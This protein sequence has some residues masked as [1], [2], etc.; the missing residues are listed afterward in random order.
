MWSVWS[1]T[2]DVYL[3]QGVAMLKAGAQETIVWRGPATLP[4]E[5]VLARL[6]D[7]AAASQVI[8]KKGSRL[9][10]SLSGAWCPATAVTIPE[11]VTR[12]EEVRQI[13][14]ASAAKDMGSDPEQVACE[15]DAMAWGVSAAVSL[16]MLHELECWATQ[17][18]CK[19]VSV[20]P[21][22]AIATQS[23]LSRRRSTKSLLV[24]EPDAAT[25]VS[26]NGKGGFRAVTWPG[27]MDGSALQAH[28]R[29]WL[30]GQGQDGSGLLSLGFGV[31]VHPRMA[32]GPVRWS[33]HWYGE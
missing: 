7:S 8:L 2:V 4:L 11:S 9:R 33:G 28:S 29:Q 19:L 26:C 6:A 1:E 16:A 18:R 3:G 10:I 23:S 15:M 17:M 31:D 14:R 13:A 25:L 32:A 24:K 20:S 5:R 30:L 27:D 22:W 21:L 12:W